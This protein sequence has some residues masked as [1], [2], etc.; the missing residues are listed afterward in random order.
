MVQDGARGARYWSAGGA[1]GGARV[2]AGGARCPMALSP[3]CARGARHWRAGG[4]TGGARV[5]AAG[6]RSLT[7]G[8]DAGSRAKRATRAPEARQA[9]HPSGRWSLRLSAERAIARGAKR[10]KYVTF[11][12]TAKNHP[13]SEAHHRPPGIFERRYYLRASGAF[14]RISFHGVM[15]VR[16]PSIHLKSELQRRSMHVAAGAYPRT[17]R[18]ALMVRQENIIRFRPQRDLSKEM[19]K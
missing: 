8:G 16:V 5:S 7:N 10:L 2:S 12:G 19:L 13:C 3:G 11:F 15:G 4:A 17:P 14:P 18:T 6:A 1:T 9:E